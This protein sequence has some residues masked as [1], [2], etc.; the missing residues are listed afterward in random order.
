MGKK[1][2][3]ASIAGKVLVCQREGEVYSEHEVGES[4]DSLQEHPDGV[5]ASIIDRQSS[6]DED[7]SGGEH[8]ESQILEG[9][10]T[11]RPDE[12]DEVQ[13]S[14]SQIDIEI[15]SD[16]SCVTYSESDKSEHD[17]SEV[18]VGFVGF[19]RGYDNED[20]RQDQQVTEIVSCCDVVIDSRIR[21]YAG[22]RDRQRYQR[23]EKEPERGRVYGFAFVSH[24]FS[25]KGLSDPCDVI[26][27]S[28]YIKPY[29]GSTRLASTSST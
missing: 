5:G 20:G 17:E 23:H 3:C 11:E 21:E 12:A 7:Q 24:S 18:A 6:E 15:S 10:R 22:E 26:R 28:K 14:Q 13:D 27:L 19:E 8:D 29:A 9:L 1:F 25:S 4:R 16:K 2:K